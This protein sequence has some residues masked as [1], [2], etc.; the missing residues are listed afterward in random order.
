MIE[1]INNL[2]LKDGDKKMKTMKS[3]LVKVMTVVLLTVGVVSNVNANEPVKLNK[4]ESAV[5][6]LK[7][8][9]NSDNTGLR[10]SGYE[11]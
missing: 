9:I 3:Y 1:T 4:R 5:E 7:S 6:N 11:M 8:A 2:K 10:K